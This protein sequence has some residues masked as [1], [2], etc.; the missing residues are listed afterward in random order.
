MTLVRYNL[1][2]TSM[3]LPPHSKN[4]QSVQ[5]QYIKAFSEVYIDFVTLT[6]VKLV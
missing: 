6:E 3:F 2:N 1:E 4:G 5:K